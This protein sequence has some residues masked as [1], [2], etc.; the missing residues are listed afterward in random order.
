[1]LDVFFHRLGKLLKDVL[2]GED[3][4]FLLEKVIFDLKMRI[5]IVILDHA[6]VKLLKL[7]LPGLL[8]SFRSTF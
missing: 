2:V 4:D 7:A 6:Q 1:M 3:L 5:S 8:N